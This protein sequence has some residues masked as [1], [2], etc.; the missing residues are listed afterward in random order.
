MLYVSSPEALM[1]PIA[2]FDHIVLAKSL[3]RRTKEVF[4]KTH[5]QL[6]PRIHDLRMGAFK[7]LLQ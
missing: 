3:D 4:N 2:D 1:I 7:L 6:A 5:F